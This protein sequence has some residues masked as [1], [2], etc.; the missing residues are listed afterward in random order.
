MSARITLWPKDKAFNDKRYEAIPHS[1]HADA[2]EVQSKKPRQDEHSRKAHICQDEHRRY[3]KFPD[4]NNEDPWEE[5]DTFKMIEAK[6][7][8]EGTAHVYPVLP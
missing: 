2:S 7:Q 6:I 3:S 5:S 8:K 4:F 1:S